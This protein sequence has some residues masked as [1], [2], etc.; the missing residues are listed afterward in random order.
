MAKRKG[1]NSRKK[2]LQRKKKVV[3]KVRRILPLT[4]IG[5]A[6]VI[7]LGAAWFSGRIGYGKLVAAI[8]GSSL[9]SIRKIRVTGNERLTAASIIRESNVGSIR[10][11]YHLNPDSIV[12][13]LS[14][15]PWI[16]RVRCLKRW[17]GE[18]VIDVKERKPF[19]LV[20]SGIVRLADE[21]GILLP[22]EP[23]KTYELPLLT[24]VPV[25]REQGGRLRCDSAVFE[26]VRRFVTTVRREDT[27]LM[28]G[29][30]QIDMGIADAA[31][32]RFAAYNAVVT[33]G[34][35]TDRKQLR[36]LRRLLE[37]LENSEGKTA[38]IDMRYQNLAF[39]ESGS[40][41]TDVN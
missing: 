35:L 10:K 26:Q 18:V 41:G 23:G 33:I 7:L 5:I 13:V 40:G 31:G 24:S 34:C 25:V 1:V 29:I 17:W 11:L 27:A 4:G 37:V 12:A 36:N 2:T 8:D 16:G 32:C 39:V 28:N 9:F 22:V 15:D 3:S 6:V 38:V 20:H 14:A 19:A 21:Q 30:S